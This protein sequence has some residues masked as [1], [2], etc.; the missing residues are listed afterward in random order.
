MSG[1]TSLATGARKWSR[2]SAGERRAFASALWLVP[3]L[4]IAVRL[5]GFQKVRRWVEATVPAPRA[6]YGS[7][8]ERIRIGVVS[9]NRVKQFSMLR[10]NCLSQSLALT[11]MLR[12][13]GIAPELCV[14]VRSTKPHFD[15]HAWVEFEGRVLN[16]SQDVHTRFTPFASDSGA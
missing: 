8:A 16:D 14:G 12:R 1:S 11:R 5:R 6:V 9:V 10:G 7:T 2:L 4:H 13:R 3:A 15:A